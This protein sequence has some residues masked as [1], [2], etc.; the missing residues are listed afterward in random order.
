[1]AIAR[2][3]I[4]KMGRWSQFKGRELNSHFPTLATY[5]RMLSA[6]MRAGLVGIELDADQLIR[7]LKAQSY[8]E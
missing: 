3:L 8:R 1:M 2:F 4:E 6:P 7:I 5:N